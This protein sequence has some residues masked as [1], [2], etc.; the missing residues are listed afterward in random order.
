[1]SAI[2]S[3]YLNINIKTRIHTNNRL[4]TSL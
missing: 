3:R 1:M 4:Y 2:I